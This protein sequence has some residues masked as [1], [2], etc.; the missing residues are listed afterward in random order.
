MR[1]ALLVAGVLALAVAAFAAVAPSKLL[2]SDG[3]VKGW[4]AVPGA[5]VEAKGDD[6]SKIYNGGYEFY[7]KNGVT[8]AARD[9]YLRGSAVMEVTVHTMKSEKAAQA[10][11]EHWKKELRAKS[12]EKKDGY[13]LFTSPKPPSGWLVSGVYL[14]SAVPSKSGVGPAKDSRTFLI[15][16]QKKIRAAGKK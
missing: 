3:A 5:R 12:V 2:P 15:A 13:A 11:F 6:I 1:K 4:K 16:V 8:S 14:I 10:F 7:V 9:L